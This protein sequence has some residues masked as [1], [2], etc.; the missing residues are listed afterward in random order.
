MRTGVTF[1]IIF[2]CLFLSSHAQIDTTKW[3]QEHED[4]E[5]TF[6]TYGF[7]YFIS[8]KGEGL[9]PNG[10][11]FTF[12][13]NLARFF[14]RKVVIGIFLDI[15][16]AKGIFHRPSTSK[17]F[18][19][20]FNTNFNTIYSSSKDS[21]RASTL[22]YAFNE[23]DM[24]GNYLNRLGVMF[25]LFP[26]RYGGIL[27][28]IKSGPYLFPVYDVF[29]D[30]AFDVGN[31]EW[32]DFVV[33]TKSFE[34]TFRPRAFFKE[35]PEGQKNDFLYSIIFSFFYE[36]MSYSSATFDGSNLGM[37][38]NPAF[39]EQYGTDE[40]YGFKIGLAIY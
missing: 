23:R 27:L 2:N 20:S 19:A 39:F 40:R 12:G 34:C 24:R 26:R 38:I 35:P 14:S 4:D 3:W 29:E 5:N 1:L 13:A 37:F 25:S 11:Y 15:K 31:S 33:P 22:N 9:N 17:E 28:T 10:T 8:P 36:K 16:F 7:S 21:S 18:L 6:V 30:P 32:A